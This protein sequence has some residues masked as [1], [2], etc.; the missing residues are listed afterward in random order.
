M[1]IYEPGEQ[2]S[3]HT[4]LFPAQIIPRPDGVPSGP[5]LRVVITE[6]AL[7]VLWAGPDGTVGR[8]DVEL[9]EEQTA[10]A[11]FNGGKVGGYT[12]AKAGGC[13]CGSK[14]ARSVD[15]FP[16]V[17]YVQVPRTKSAVKTYGV[18]PDR[19]QRVRS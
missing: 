3:I 19:Y 8:W 6:R 11:T 12:V 17:I 10:D 16:G 15:P 13:G 4:D 1:S 18:P 2:V 5:K 7:T 14:A 9:T